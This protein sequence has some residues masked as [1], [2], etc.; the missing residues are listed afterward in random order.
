MAQDGSARDRDRASGWR[1]GLAGQL[2]D[3]G[4]WFE[5]RLVPEPDADVEV[6]PAERFLDL[7]YLRDAVT[8]A[9]EGLAQ[10]WGHEQPDVDQSD[11]SDDDDDD[12]EGDENV[13]LRLAVSRFT[14]HYTASLTAVALVGLAR[15]VGLDLS[16]A[17]CQL[18]IWRDLPFRTVLTLD[19]DRVLTCPSRPAAWPVQGRSVATVGEL[20]EHV[21]RGLYAGNIAPLLSRVRQLTRVTRSLMWTNAAEWVGLVS[22]AAEEYLTPD[23]APPF[24]ADR[25]ALLAAPTLPGLDGPNPL[26]DRVEWVPVDGSE[27]PREVMTRQV[28]CGTYLL[29]DRGGRLCQNCPFLPLEDRVALIRE[30][31][32]VSMG[33]AGGPAEQRSIELGRR[34]MKAT[35]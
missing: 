15:G 25:M 34:R 31:H 2:D 13:D 5:G 11:Q 21:W 28:C 33:G 6:V 19:D 7:D 30:R 3:L 16:A 1:R 22:D 12:D 4:R 8:R 32:G 35:T 29:A 14:R 10:W 23:E 17:N 18:V 20:R 26:L 9:G 24:V 27:F